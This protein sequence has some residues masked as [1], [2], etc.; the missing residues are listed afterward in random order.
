LRP[1]RGA[2]QRWLQA[3]ERQPE[4]RQLID[5]PSG[6]TAATVLF[7]DVYRA[8]AG[9]E[10]RNALIFNDVLAA[11]EAGRSP[12]VIPERT[13]HV[14]AMA[15]RLSRFARNVTILRGGQSERKRREA[16]ARLAAFPER[17][18]RRT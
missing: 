3:L 4:L 16:M 15:D 13:D 1:S 8:L 18:E 12:V 11:L 14:E 9:N 10:D 6:A 5:A 7:E 17:E 2:D